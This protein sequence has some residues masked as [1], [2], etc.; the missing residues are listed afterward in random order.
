MTSPFSMLFV[1]TYIAIYIVIISFWIKVKL[2]TT[3]WI[4]LAFVPLLMFTIKYGI[5]PSHCTL[6]TSPGGLPPF[7]SKR[8]LKSKSK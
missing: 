8:K 2:T 7:N 5:Q 3:L 1:A 6:I 4:L